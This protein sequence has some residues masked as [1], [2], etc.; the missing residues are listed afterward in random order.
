M[1]QKNKTSKKREGW[2]LDIRPNEYNFEDQPKWITDTGGKLHEYQIEGINWIRYSWGQRE[3]TILADEMGL[4]KTIQTISFVYSLFKEGRSDGPFLICAP[5]STL[6]NWE[7]EFEF[8]APDM[9]VVTYSGNRD[10]RIVIRFVLIFLSIFHAILERSSR[11][12]SHPISH[13]HKIM[14]NCSTPFSF[15]FNFLEIMKCHSMKNPSRKAQK[16]TK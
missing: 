14:K 2:E 12:I 1:K 4:G 7:R 6:V 9:Y 10:N 5:L 8:W 3:N 15:I 16:L 11:N 13:N